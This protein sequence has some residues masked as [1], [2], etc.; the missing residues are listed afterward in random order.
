MFI[1]FSEET[2]HLL[3]QAQKEMFDLNHPYV[4]SEHLLL[5]ILKEDNNVSKI[6]KKYNVTYS[7]F[8][9]KLIDIVGTGT[10]QSKY[11]LYT[12]LLK[13][14]LENS[15]I[16]ARENNNKFVS[17]EILIISILDEED[18]IAFSILKSMN[19]NIEKLYYDI[20]SNKK[21]K[22]NKK[23]KLLLEE[24]GTNLTK[25]ASENKLDPVIGRDTETKNVIE[26]LLRRKKNNPI[27]IGPAGVGK[28]AIV[29]GLATL[30]NSNNVPEHLKNTKIIALNIFSLVA[31]T[32]YRGEFEEKMKT[33][34]RELEDNEDIILFIDEIHTIV[35]AGGAEGAIDAS[36]IFKPALARG[37]IKI[38]GA[39][40][41]DEYKKYIEPDAALARRF[42]RVN[43]EEPNSNS[44]INILKKIKPLYELYHNVILDNYVLEKIVSL[45]KKYMP[46][47]FEPDKSIDILDEVC[48]R[49]SIKENQNE[50]HNKII[51]KKLTEIE[52]QKEQALI[53][54]NYKKALELKKEELQ[55]KNKINNYKTKKRVTIND[56]IDVVSVKASVPIMKSKS[57]SRKYYL[58]LKK[59]LNEKVLGQE[60]NIEELIL[61]LKRKEYLNKNCYSV[62]ITGN[63]GSGKTLL[64]E[65]YV[66]LLVGE[67]NIINID[68]TEYV[69]SNS[70]SK[71][72]GTTAG[73]L[74]YDNKNNIFEKVRTT[75]YSAIILDNINMCC[76]DVSNL[77]IRILE[78]GKI[79]DASGKMID[80]S[81]TIIIM[82]LNI[83]QDNLGFNSEKTK[84]KI[85]ELSNKLLNKIDAVIR[86][87]KL[88]K[89]S[90]EKII[91]IKVINILKKY[92]SNKKYDIT[93]IVTE[94][95]KHNDLSK[96]DNLIYEKIEKDI[97]NDLIN[98]NSLK[99][100]NVL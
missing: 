66:K 40:T 94:V 83:E 58:R 4:G 5:A 100:S 35:G 42:Q 72:I 60:D 12:P 22:V 23:K 45:S 44:V 50:K 32:K 3:K 8:K 17:P 92:N 25:L 28:T 89:S 9:N 91:N 47:K 29:E 53:N 64:A 54:N 86:L 90:I 68:M 93:D 48:T 55:L 31:G 1:N 78:K 6:I 24:L 46:D 52:S 62:L 56:V 63:Q 81:N 39:T 67:N 7:N 36:N 88:D 85:K 26:I 11:I 80:F 30:I 13:R 49:T 61:S 70:I 96:I 99:T 79:E 59:L 95:L 84:N 71:L 69:E 76:E 51:L 21:N 20:K 33:I 77:F 41:L 57:D 19:V 2:Q 14:I 38:I 97:M 74:G 98:E 15:T 75:P 43:V 82:T 37:T 87:N 16:E 65:E 73:Y 10:K 18:G 34:L 27:L